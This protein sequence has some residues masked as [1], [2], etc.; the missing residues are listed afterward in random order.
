MSGDLKE[1]H[2]SIPLGELS[3]VGV[4]SSVCFI[5]ILIL[6]S[7]VDRTMLLCDNLIEEK[8]VL[9]YSFSEVCVDLPNRDLLHGRSLRLFS[10]LY[11]WKSTRNTQSSSRNRSRRNHPCYESTSS[12][13]ELSYRLESQEIAERSKQQPSPGRNGSNG[14]RLRFCP[15]RRLERSQLDATLRQSLVQLAILS[16]MPFMITYAFVNYAYVSLAMSYDLAN[17]NLISNPG[18]SYGSTQGEGDLNELFPERKEQCIE[19]GESRQRKYTRKLQ[20]R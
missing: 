7:T 15:V 8:V 10:L 20:E 17:V 13:S 1:P 6:G 5:F 9:L 19:T 11:H 12:G 16:T 18:Q 3:A 4:S 2:K 14:C